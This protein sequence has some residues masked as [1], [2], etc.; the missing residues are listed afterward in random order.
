MLDAGEEGELAGGGEEAGFDGVGGELAELREG[1]AEVGVGEGVL[2]EQA[3]AEH[4]RVVGVEGDHE[5]EVEVGAQ[6]VV[7]EGGAAA[8]AQVGGDADLDGELAGGE[9]LHEFGV[10]VGGEG[11]ADAL[12]AD[13]DGGP[14]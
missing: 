8:G 3:G 13:V 6:G 10:V 7:V 5:A 11:V 4:G 14:D 1:E 12:G 9:D 2:V